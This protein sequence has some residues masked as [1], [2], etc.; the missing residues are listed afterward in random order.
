MD[1]AKK[2]LRVVLDTNILISALIF[3]GVLSKIVNLWKDGSV[4]PV[5]TKETFNEFREVL[6]YPKFSLTKTEINLILEEEI[7]PYFEVVKV[8][9]SVKEVCRDRQDDKFISCAIAAR[10]D[11]IVSGDEDLLVLKKY[12]QTK[13]IFASE[14]LG[15]F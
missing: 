7:L 12:G 13:I 14:F 5:L 15:Q 6:N 1:K 9:R 3:T 8:A 4:V 10:A 11:Y 2:E